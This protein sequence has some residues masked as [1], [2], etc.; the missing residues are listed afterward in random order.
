MNDLPFT[1]VLLNNW[2]SR[3]DGVLNYETVYFISD[4]KCTEMIHRLLAR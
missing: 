1:R 4:Y 3:I 2:L